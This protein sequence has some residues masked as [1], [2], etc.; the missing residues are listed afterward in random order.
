MKR[1]NLFN[2]TRMKVG[3][4]QCDSLVEASYVSYLINER[5]TPETELSRSTDILFFI[6]HPKFHFKS[7]VTWEADAM[8]FY[9]DGQIRV[10]DVKGKPTLERAGFKD[11]MKLMAEEYPYL[12]LWIVQRTANGTWLEARYE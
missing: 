1:P 7:G 9:G 3:P 2:A 12:D 8:I 4:Y 6:F 10:I 5:D 11:K